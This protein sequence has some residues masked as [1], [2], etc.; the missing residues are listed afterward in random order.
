[1]ALRL[2]DASSS[3]WPP[4]RKVIPVEQ[5]GKWG[6][7]VV[8]RDPGTGRSPQKLIWKS[9]QMDV[10]MVG[11][12]HLPPRGQEE[13]VGLTSDSGGHCAAQCC[14]SC[15]GN[16]LMRIFMG[17][18]VPWGYHVGLQQSAFQ[19]DMVVTQ[20]FVDSSQHLEQSRAKVG[21]G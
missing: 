7:V 18:G 2:M 6:E 1:M 4:E 12:V 13:A 16:L 10:K 3:L 15:H 19:V 9:E 17:A 8:V 11:A 14:D 21:W 20:S 5:E